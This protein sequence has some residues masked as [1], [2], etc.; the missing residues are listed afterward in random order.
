MLGKTVAQ[1]VVVL[2][3]VR[4]V[5]L[6]FKVS[7]HYFADVSGKTVMEDVWW[8]VCKGFF[9]SALIPLSLKLKH[10]ES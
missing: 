1:T 7:L 10:L 6:G 4:E 8:F 9:F 5:I 2:W 3:E